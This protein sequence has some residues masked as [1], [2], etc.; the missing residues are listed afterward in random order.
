MGDSEGGES[1][2]SPFSAVA[3]IHF[4]QAFIKVNQAVADLK[5]RAFKIMASGQKPV[6]AD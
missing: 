4:A 1:R 5:P 6:K 3:R 2:F